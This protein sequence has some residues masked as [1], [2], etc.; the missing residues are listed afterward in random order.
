MGKKI[1]RST[2]NRIVKEE[3]QRYFL[4][5]RVKQRLVQEGFFQNVKGFFSPRDAMIEFIKATRD[6]SNYNQSPYMI[7]KETGTLVLRPS[8]AINFKGHTPTSNLK[9][10]LMNA[11]RANNKARRKAEELY[12][13]IPDKYKKGLDSIYDF[14]AANKEMFADVDEREEHDQVEDFSL[15]SNIMNAKPPHQVKLIVKGYEAWRAGNLERMEKEREAEIARKEKDKADQEKYRNKKDAEERRAR[16]AARDAEERDKQIDRDIR[17]RRRA[18][19]PD[20]LDSTPRKYGR[21][22]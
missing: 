1:K 13:A 17:D 9:G 15:S 18:E 7:D 21:G 16:A 20:Y 10:A 8:A 11:N 3:T 2:L 5:K 6:P 12:T 4:E 14:M 19:E 22:G